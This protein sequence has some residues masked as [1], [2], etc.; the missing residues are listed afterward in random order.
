MGNEGDRLIP[1]KLVK[2]SFKVGKPNPMSLRLA[3]DRSPFT[4]PCTAVESNR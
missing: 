2:V 1:R 3:V 4:V